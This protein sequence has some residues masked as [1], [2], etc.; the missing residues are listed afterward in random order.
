MLIYSRYTWWVAAMV[1]F[2]LFLGAAGQVGVLNPFQ[3]MFLQLTSPLES[4][5]LGVFQPVADVLSNA[6]E[7]DELQDQNDRLRIENEELRNRVAELEQDTQELAELRQAA[8]I[9][10]ADTGQRPL[11]ATIVTRDLSA[12]TAVVRIDRGGADG[13]KDGM[14]VL[15]A[16]GTLL[17]TV[18]K[19]LDDTAF[20]R[21]IT[22]TQSKVN[23]KVVDSSADGI[24]KGTPGRGLTFDL[25]Q[26]DIK[27]GDIVMTS[28][29]GGN[30]PQDIPIGR[31]TA[32]S[33]N[34][35]D[36]FKKVTLEPGVRASTAQTVLVLTSFIPQRIEV[37]E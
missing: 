27:V 22:D 35:Q 6:G 10:R 34:S 7:M 32:V 11:A 13:I 36:L 15:S 33:G 4:A 26:G 17:G 21:L 28:G 30:Y 2:A 9:I 19:V 20:V 12:F 5:T 25:A 8:G 3:G 37:G 24:V 1:A 29:L 16:Q 14:V 31:V 18:T 23:A